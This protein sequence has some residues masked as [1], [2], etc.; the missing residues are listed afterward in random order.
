MSITAGNG[1]HHIKKAANKTNP[2]VSVIIP[3]YDRT[4]YISDAV[5]SVTKQTYL[6][7]EIIIVDDGS[8]TKFRRKLQDIP[9]KHSCVK[10]HHLPDHRGVSYA[11][12]FGL[13]VALGDYVLFLDDD[14]TLHPLM[15]ETALEILE[16]NPTVAGVF[17][18]YKFRYNIAISQKALSLTLLFNYHQLK[19]VSF[20][21]KPIDKFTEK[22]L[23]S[24][25]IYT[26]LKSYIAIHSCLLRKAA[27]GDT[28]FPEELV[29][30]EDK[31]FWLSLAA[32]RCVF[33]I[34]AKD[35][36]TVGRHAMNYSQN[37]SQDEKNKQLAYYD[38]LK[39][40]KLLQCRKS[41]ALAYLKLLHI[42]IGLGLP[43]RPSEILS[44]LSSPDIILGQIYLFCKRR[45]LLRWAFVRYYFTKSKSGPGAI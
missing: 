22:Q 41:R 3:T 13:S 9:I 43:L 26:L 7:S 45:L 12:N 18:Q 29:F 30:G 6:V 15:I 21:F 8:S 35:Y 40:K 38:T 4:D 2:V 19:C 16:N 11:R 24:E 28:R 1:N 10:L 44:I 34:V 27:I 36:A 23:A 33:R 32:N 42:R 37:S 20:P 5:A 25:P 39:R 14:D 17:C 31:C